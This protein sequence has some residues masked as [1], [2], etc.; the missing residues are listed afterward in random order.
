MVNVEVEIAKSFSYG[1]TSYSLVRHFSC[2]MYRL[3]TIN[4]VRER[5]TV[6]D[7]K[8][9][10]RQCHANSLSDSEWK[11]DRPIRLSTVSYR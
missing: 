11:Y 9:D 1:G 7:V 5:R 4:F 3:A 8:T 6:T 10:I 2:T